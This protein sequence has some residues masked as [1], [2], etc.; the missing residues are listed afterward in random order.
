[1]RPSSLLLS[2]VLG[3]LPVAAQ[4]PER[5]KLME[6]AKKLSDQ[7]ARGAIYKQAQDIYLEQV[8]IQISYIGA[9]AFSWNPK[10]EGVVVFGDPSQWAWGIMNW[11]FAP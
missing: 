2:L 4:Q 5:Y 7:A 6:D 1:M 9:N 10:L 11:K 8:P 3:A